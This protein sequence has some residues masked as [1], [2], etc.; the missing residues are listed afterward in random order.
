MLFK[1]ILG[2][3]N[4]NERRIERSSGS[5]ISEYNRFHDGTVFERRNEL[6]DPHNCLK[7]A[8]AVANAPPAASIPPATVSNSGSSSWIE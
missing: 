1:N 6:R 8:V 4:N 2:D 7:A 5:G 3:I